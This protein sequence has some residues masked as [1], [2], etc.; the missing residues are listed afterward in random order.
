MRILLVTETVPFPLDSGGRIKTFHT[1]QTLG[2][3][4]D[5]WC[6][7]FARSPEQRDAAASELSKR[8]RGVQLPVVA[9]SKV[10]EA[11]YFARSL[12]TGLPYTV[13]RHFDPAALAEM[14]ALCD[15]QQIDVVYCDHLSMF[16]YARR[17]DRPIVYDA[18]NVEHRIVARQAQTSGYGPVRAVLA[19]EWRRLRAYEARACAE[20]AL[21]LAVSDVDA[22]ALSALAGEWRAGAKAVGARPR[23]VSLPIAVDAA[24]ARPVAELPDEPTVLFVGGL[25]WPPNADAVEFFLGAA[26]P[27]VRVAV[28]A[29]RM[30]VVGRA[31]ERLAAQWNGQAGV[32]F[33]GRV[34]DVAP[35]FAASRVVVVPIRSGSGLRVKILDAFSH[36]RPVVATTVGAEGLAVRH[37][38]NILL[39]DEPEALAREVTRVLT[40]RPLAMR[41]AA[42]GRDTVLEHYDVPVI[43]RQLLALMADVDR[44]I[45]HG[46]RLPRK[47]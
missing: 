28:P 13:V 27:Q 24:A 4:H 37:G 43:G 46:C 1:L 5:L 12:A 3:A 18:H 23:V 8:C 22:E 19:R 33:T 40:D 29:A 47:R 21:V 32:T 38:A 26:W 36:Q 20:S 34:D 31:A 35:W 41:L 30:I 6:V 11:A 42:A 45:A 16:E 2:S 39:A 15:A 10:R 7:A 25:D 9:R 44:G 14:Q 17:L